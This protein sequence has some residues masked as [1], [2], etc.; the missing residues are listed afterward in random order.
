MGD[1]ISALHLLQASLT[2]HFKL[3]DDIEICS[4]AV[5]QA[6]PKRN[7]GAVTNLV[8]A[9]LQDCSG[10]ALDAVA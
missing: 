2:S 9:L 3:H 1:G 5:S 7:T 6:C 10:A 4:Q 8:K